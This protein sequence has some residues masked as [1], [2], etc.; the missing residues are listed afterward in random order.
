[1]S[2]DDLPYGCRHKDHISLVDFSCAQWRH[3]KLVDPPFVDRVPI[4]FPEALL[5]VDSM[6]QASEPPQLF[7]RPALELRW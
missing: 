4:C 2:P 5:D 7:W 6:A 3:I 1:M